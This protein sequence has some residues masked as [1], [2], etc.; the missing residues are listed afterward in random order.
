MKTK[1]SR[2]KTMVTPV[3]ARKELSGSHCKNKTCQA[4]VGASDLVLYAHYDPHVFCSHDCLAEWL[5]T[6]IRKDKRSIM[7]KV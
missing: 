4:R 3:E 7:E 1:Y 6:S 2:K 5:M